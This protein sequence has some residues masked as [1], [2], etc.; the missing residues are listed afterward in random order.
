MMAATGDLETSVTTEVERYCVNP[1]QAC[2]YMICRQAINRMR[3][4]ARAALGERF[5]L[6]GFHD[7]ML[8][9]GA[10]PLSVLERIMNDWVA[11]RR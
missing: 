9:N 6:K 3:D 1:G 11:S 8:A 5:D 10:V 4:S 7:T 2:A